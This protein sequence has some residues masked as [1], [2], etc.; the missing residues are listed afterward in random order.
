MKIFVNYGALQD[1]IETKNAFD[2]EA[3]NLSSYLFK[4]MRCVLGDIIRAK[5]LEKLRT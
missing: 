1:T 3:E 4:R 2:I 5:D